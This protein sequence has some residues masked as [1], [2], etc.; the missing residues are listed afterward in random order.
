MPAD[1]ADR[2]DF[3]NANRGLVAVLEPAQVRADDGKLVYD[4]AGF[5]AA[6]A[7]DCPDTVNP[8]LWRQAQLTAIHGLFEVTT[9]GIYQIRGYDLSNMTLVEARRGG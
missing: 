8:S 1:F 7:G 4:A 6:T 3:D 5:A 9:G 2:T